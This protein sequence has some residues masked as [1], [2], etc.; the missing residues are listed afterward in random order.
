M[1]W[2]QA[3]KVRYLVSGR[4]LGLLTNISWVFSGF[5]FTLGCYSMKA[6]VQ[7]IFLNMFLFWMTFQMRWYYTNH[8]QMTLPHDLAA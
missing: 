8:Q 5:N 3:L 4:S 7:N 1:T 6:L 2:E